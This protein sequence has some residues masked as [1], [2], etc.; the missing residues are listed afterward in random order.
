MSKMSEIDITLQ[1]Y[2]ES[3]HTNGHA[4]PLT[5]ELKRELLGYGLEDVRDLVQGIDLE[6]DTLVFNNQTEGRF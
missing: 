5:V 6:F 1:D 2:E 4:D 3:L